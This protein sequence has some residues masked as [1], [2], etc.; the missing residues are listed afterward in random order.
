MT[1]SDPPTVAA[2]AGGGAS[3][4]ATPRASANPPAPL[5]AVQVLTFLCSIG[6][7]LVTNGI[8][9]LTDAAYGFGR[10]ENLLLMCGMGATYIVG[11]KAASSMVRVLRRAVPA[12]SSR[13][14]LAGLMLAM[15][16]LVMLPA[17]F[18]AGR[19]AAGA[20]TGVWVVWTV[21]LIYSPMTGILWPMVES[22]LSG[23]RSGR[24]LRSVIGIWNVVWS[25]AIIVPY[26]GL[27]ALVKSNPVVAFEALAAVHV[28]C[29]VFL[30]ACFPKEPAPHL[31]EHHEPHPQVYTELLVVFRMLLPLSYF[32]LS[33]INPVLPALMGSIG[34]SDSWKPIVGTAWLAPRVVTFFVMSRWHGWHGR[35]GSPIAG[36]AFM[37]SGFA[38]AVLSPLLGAGTGAV[39]LMVAGLGVLGVGLAVIYSGAIYYAME[40]GKAEVDAGGTH[41]AL[42]GLGYTLGPAC[43]LAAGGL[44][45]GGVMG[46]KWFEVMVVVTVSAVA[47]GVA[48]YAVRHARAKAKGTA[49]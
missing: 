1:P 48:G 34:V 21:V 33:A 11:A 44:V 39:M 43:G 15:G 29:A 45:A 7:G 47:L 20:R 32:V 17:V 6:T 37:L 49:G 23:G 42:I 8:F 9:Y 14:F 19:D 22:F 26:L 4:T 5:W 30:V 3:S 10:M 12:L 25:G 16:A 13:G 35:W 41:E 31:A 46:D 24:E 27:A 18:H 40:V 36:A 28:A 2:A 38:M